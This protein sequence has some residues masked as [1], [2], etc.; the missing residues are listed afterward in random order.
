MLLLLELRLVFL[1][2]VHLLLL[3]S[4]LDLRSLLEP[5]PLRFIVNRLLVGATFVMLHLLWCLHALSHEILLLLM[6]WTEVYA[7]ADVVLGLWPLLMD[8]RN[9]WH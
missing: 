6:D 4:H 7:L 9:V 5:V 3:L 2:I 1:L 8:L